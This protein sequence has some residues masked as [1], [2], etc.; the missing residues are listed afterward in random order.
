MEAFF[1]HNILAIR[2]WQPQF[3]GYLDNFD[4]DWETNATNTEYQS[5]LYR[6]NV[7]Y[8]PERYVKLQEITEKVVCRGCEVFASHVPIC[9]FVI[10]FALGLN[11][12][13]IVLICM[14]RTGWTLL[15]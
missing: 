2:K 10:T 5:K 6:R 9:L 7:P 15:L 12:L 1:T 14:T 4:E 13:W 11:Y 8:E 3:I